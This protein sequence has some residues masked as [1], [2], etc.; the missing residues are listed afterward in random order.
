MYYV[1]IFDLDRTLLKVNSSFAFGRY[2]Y[3][4]RVFSFFDMLY[5]LGC[6]AAHKVNLLSIHSL[7]HKIFKRL[8]FKR[9][10]HLFENAVIAFLNEMDDKFLNPPAIR[11]LELAKARGDRVILLSSS[12]HFLVGPIANKL[13]ISEWVGSHYAIDNDSCFCHI[14]SLVQGN[15]KALYIEALL[16]RENLPRESIVAY[17]DSYH[18]LPFLK[19]AG[20][21][22]GVNPDRKLKKLCYKYGWKIL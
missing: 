3:K 2:L 14:A 17:S 1:S 11:C 18:D 6:Y 12:P 19:A 5:M 22:V 9:S 8:F 16:K 10:I 20:Q 13:Q 7:H 21:A 15:E 4:N